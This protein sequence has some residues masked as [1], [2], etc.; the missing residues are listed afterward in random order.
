M[1][2]AAVLPLW[3]GS[4]VVFPDL[5]LPVVVAVRLALVPAGKTDGSVGARHGSCRRNFGGRG[6]GLRL[7]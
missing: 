1:A 7:G 4:H 3:L 2:G 6:R 5:A